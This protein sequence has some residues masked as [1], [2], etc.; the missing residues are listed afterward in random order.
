MHLRSRL[1]VL[2]LLVVLPCLVVVLVAAGAAWFVAL[3][4]LVVG[5]SLLAS[6]AAF[7]GAPR[8]SLLGPLIAAGVTVVVAGYVALLI[9]FVYLC[10]QNDSGAY[11]GRG[12]VRAAWAAAALVYLAVG[13]W[14]ARAPARLAWAWPVAVAGGLVTFLGLLALLE[15]GTHH[16]YL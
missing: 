10:D 14:G 12:G 2:P 7:P 11:V 16:C 4:A 9:A 5:V 3:L 1:V 6:P 13:A 15:G 8:Y